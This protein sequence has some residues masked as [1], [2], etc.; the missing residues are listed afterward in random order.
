MKKKSF[1][2]DLSLNRETIAQLG[3]SQM[4]I[5]NGGELEGDTGGKRCSKKCCYS[6]KPP[7][8]QPAQFELEEFEE[9]NNS[10]K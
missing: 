6:Y 10:C 7:E 4:S 2:R 3:L 5:I 9:F 8:K 1:N